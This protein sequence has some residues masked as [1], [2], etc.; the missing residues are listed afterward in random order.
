MSNPSEDDLIQC[1]CGCIE[2]T[3]S[4]DGLI[5]CA[6]CRHPTDGHMAMEIDVKTYCKVHGVKIVSP[7]QAI[8]DIAA[9][10]KE[11][12]IPD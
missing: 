2:F 7:S 10:D 5:E 3:V 11:I 1:E 4:R 6:E 9:I 12:G 8:D